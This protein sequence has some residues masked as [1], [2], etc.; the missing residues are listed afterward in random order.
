MSAPPVPVRPTPVEAAALLADLARGLAA[1]G[2][3]EDAVELGLDA[4]RRLEQISSDVIER[5]PDSGLRREV[6]L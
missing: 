1:A 4:A 6:T 3:L 2:T 5:G